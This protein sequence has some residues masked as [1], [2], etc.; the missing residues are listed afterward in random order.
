MST[1]ELEIESRKKIF[2][3]I[4]EYPGL[5][6]RE[7][8]RRTD[9]AM[10]LARYHLG[11]LK[12]YEMV[13]EVEEN[14]YKRYYP[15]EGKKRV[16]HRDKR[17]LTFLRQEI[18]LSVVVY[19]LNKGKAVSHSDIKKEL[20]IPAST[21]SYHL[22][23]M[24]K[25]GI[26]EKNGRKYRVTEPNVVTGLLIKYGPPKDIIDNFIDIWESLSL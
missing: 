21:L 20:G 1:P 8:S 9:L 19:M 18:P 23:K 5:H 4:E 6:M 11:Q 14:E 7:I 3:L 13:E 10:N 2:K 17:Y 26:L 22:K 12:R 15:K 24:Q 25:K 16:D